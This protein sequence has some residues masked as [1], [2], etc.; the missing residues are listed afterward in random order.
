[1]DRMG[2]HRLCDEETAWFE[3]ALGLPQQFQKSLV[4]EV[5]HHLSGEHCS[6]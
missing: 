4:I 3:N 5:F 2:I 1:M 6:N